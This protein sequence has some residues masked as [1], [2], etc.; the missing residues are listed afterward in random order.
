MDDS[1]TIRNPATQFD[2]LF[3]GRGSLPVSRTDET[4]AMEK[5]DKFGKGAVLELISSGQLMNEI[6]IALGVPISTFRKWMDQNVTAE[7]LAAARRACAESFMLKSL[8]VLTVSNDAPG[9]ASIIRAYADRLAAVA[10]RLDPDNWAQR[11][12]G[13]DNSAPVT[14]VFEGMGG[15]PMKQAQ[16]VDGQVDE[17][18]PQ[19]ELDYVLL[20]ADDHE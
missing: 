12:P 13:G 7:E 8:L 11:K 6:A 9:H 2:V 15:A 14:I 5:I 1:V 19:E 20:S 3:D 17:I 4:R 18:N 16:V 10:E